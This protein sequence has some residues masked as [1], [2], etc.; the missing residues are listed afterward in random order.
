MFKRDLI[1]TIEKVDGGYKLNNS[2]TVFNISWE[3]EREEGEVATAETIEKIMDAEYDIEYDEK[4]MAPAGAIQIAEFFFS[5]AYVKY[6]AGDFRNTPPRV[7][8]KKLRT[9][10]FK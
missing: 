9:P 5:D 7:V 4:V 8:S 3:D 2:V 6:L 1:K 10:S